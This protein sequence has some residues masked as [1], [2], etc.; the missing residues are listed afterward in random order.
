M[1]HA[2]HLVHAL[3]RALGDRWIIHRHEMQLDIESRC[4][5]TLYAPPRRAVDWIELL[6]CLE[7][8]F[9]SHG[10][11]RA[12]PLPLACGRDTDFTISAIQA[13]DPYLKDNQP[14]M[15]REGFLA[16]PVVR[17]TGDRTPS[18]Q[19]ADGFLTS[20]VNIAQVSRIRNIT[21]HATH[22]DSWIGILGAIGLHA[23]H[24]RITGQTQVWQRGPVN[25]ITLHIEHAGME[26]SDI[27]LLWNAT[28]PDHLVT[29]IGSGL[30]RLRWARH[31]CD[32]LMNVHGRRSS[33]A[34]NTLDAVRTAA[35]VIG[36]GVRP[37]P[38]GRG[39][40]IRRLLTN[41]SPSVSELGVSRATRSACEY[42]STFV[43]PA[44]PWPAIATQ[45][46]NEIAH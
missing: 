15:L 30:E 22:L 46:D 5:A 11:A 18:G 13:A 44:L 20:F 3:R 39:G 23:R 38:R 40:T 6:G 32:W 26:I 35:L 10:I 19:L 14:I 34:P 43:P 27:V 21:D 36:Q 45:I 29:D 12:T 17:F 31:R 28:N 9:N 41:V 16:Q 33:L 2:D 24:L 4:A 25:G 37:G 7:A 42:W 1:N 8:A